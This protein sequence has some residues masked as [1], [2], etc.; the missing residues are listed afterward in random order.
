[1]PL[2][3]RP[4]FSSRKNELRPFMVEAQTLAW[5]RMGA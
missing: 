5:H 4:Y 2:F 3:I 1:L